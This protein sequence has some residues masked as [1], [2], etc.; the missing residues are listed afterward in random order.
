MHPSLDNGD[1]MMR[2]QQ[3]GAAY[4]SQWFPPPLPKVGLWFWEV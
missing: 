2:R 1:F 4:Y 3:R